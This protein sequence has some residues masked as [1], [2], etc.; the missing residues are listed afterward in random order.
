[1]RPVGFYYNMFGFIPAIKGQ[2]M[3]VQNYGGD[4]KEPWVSPLDIAAAIAE[5][6][7]KPFQGRTVRYIASDEVSP[8]EVA[9]VLGEELGKPDLH[10]CA[11]TDEQLLNGMIGAGMN[12]V[13]AKG[14][15]DMNASRVNGVLYEDY[16]RNRP[17]LG[18]MK[19][20]DFAKEFATVY[21]Q[22]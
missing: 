18:K 13:I 10:W 2:D 7:E 12:P 1:M 20:V 5:E 9:K 17:T 4:E 3:I 16:Y 14:L 6:M 15:V 11:I 22:Q 19:L 8:N 21:N